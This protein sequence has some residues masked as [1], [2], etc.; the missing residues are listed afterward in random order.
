MDLD[1]NEHK[2]NL[3]FLEK[4]AKNLEVFLEKPT[5]HVYLLQKVPLKQNLLLL[6]R[7]D[8]DIFLLFSIIKKE[9]ILAT[10]SV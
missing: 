3:T 2:L 8:C 4:E 10:F 6:Y 9:A 5:R 7:A 1:L